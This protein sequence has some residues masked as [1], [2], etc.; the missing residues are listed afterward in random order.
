[1]KCLFKIK[2][3]KKV[4]RDEIER[5]RIREIELTDLNKSLLEYISKTEKHANSNVDSILRRYEKY[6]VK[7]RDERHFIYLVG[8][9]L[10]L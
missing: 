7:I 6:Q 5:M 9:Y 1:M 8:L 2:K 10:R 3:L 4:I